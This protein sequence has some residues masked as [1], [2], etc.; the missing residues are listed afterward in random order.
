MSAGYIKLWRDLLDHE[1][2][3]REKFTDGQAWVDLLMLA[4]HTDGQ[5]KSRGMRVKVKRGQ[6]GWGVKNLSSRWRWSR[7]KVYRFLEFL[8]AEKM[9]VVEHQKIK[10]NLLLTIVNYDD[11]QGDG[12]SNRTSNDTSDG[13][14]TDIKRN[15]EQE[16]KEGKEGKRSISDVQK[17]PE[18]PKETWLTPF[19]DVWREVLGGEIQFGHAAK[20]LKPLVDRHGPE[21]VAAHL[22]NYLSSTETQFLSL[23]KFSATFGKWNVPKNESPLD[24]LQRREKEK[25]KAL[26]PVDGNG[27]YE[28]G[29]SDESL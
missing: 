25:A 26:S 22:R 9:L 12:T 6:V 16:G 8:E 18:K 23:P 5:F 3:G 24:F 1:I 4:N 15:T 13:H 28:E 27:E 10:I 14:Q 20:I 19:A 11:W 29:E 7:G 21:K 2:W 17:V